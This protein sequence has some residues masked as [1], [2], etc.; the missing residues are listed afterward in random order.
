ML[1]RCQGL[2]T[3]QALE[4][5]DVGRSWFRTFHSSAEYV[6]FRVSRGT[7]TKL[8]TK[9]VKSELVTQSNN[10]MFQ[11]FLAARIAR[12]ITS[13]RIE[14]A[15]L[16]SSWSLISRFALLISFPKISLDMGSIILLI[17]IYNM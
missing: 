10:D 15:L 14:V 8:E 12:L 4:S 7:E 5:G 16:S 13:G 9:T 17:C 11:A 3:H 1:H 2:C 6:D